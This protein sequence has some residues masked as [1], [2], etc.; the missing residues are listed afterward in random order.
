MKTSPTQRS[1]KLLRDRGYIC[2]ISEKWIPASPAGFKGPIVRSDL[3]G[4][5]DICAVK[6]GV[7]GTTYVQTTSGSNVS[8]RVEKIK[9]LAAA[10]IVKASGNKIVVHGWRTVGERGK[11][12]LWECR[13]VEV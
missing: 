10:G 2:G 8:A 7:P 13:E 11:R 4:F 6:I 5:A 12:K 1:L 3:W 9:G